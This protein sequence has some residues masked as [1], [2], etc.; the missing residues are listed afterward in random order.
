MSGNG[1]RGA[2]QTAIERVDPRVFSARFPK[3]CRPE[4]CRSRCCRF[5]VWADAGE[6]RDILEHKGLF[7]PYLRPEARDPARWFG[8][9]EADRDCPSG[10]A[11]ET[12]TVGDACVFFNPAFG[13]ALQKGAAAAGLHE[14][15]FKPR[16]CIMFPLV[17]SGG[18]LTVDEEMASLWCMKEQNRTHPI[19]YSVRKEIS[20]LFG[21]ELAKKLEQ[22]ARGS[23]PERKSA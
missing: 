9:A 22:A 5:G 18:E 21:D 7:L 12:T 4:L 2:A 16:F 19:L 1:R 3:V 20:Y 6:M 17:V 23:R 14:W 8:R 13:C 10:T 11:V 15:R